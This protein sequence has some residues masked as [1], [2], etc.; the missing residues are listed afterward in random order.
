MKRA[1][2]IAARVLDRAGLDR[3]RHSRK[4]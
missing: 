3:S 2:A 1:M 4:D